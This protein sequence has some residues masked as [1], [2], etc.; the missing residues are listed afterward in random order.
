MPGAPAGNALLSPT[1]IHENI[2]YFEFYDIIILYDYALPLRAVG[3]GVPD[4]PFEII[5][6]FTRGVQETAPYKR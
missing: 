4:G 3:A 1:K 6:I 5:V 2:D